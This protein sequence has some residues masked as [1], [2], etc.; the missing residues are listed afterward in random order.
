MVR[1]RLWLSPSQRFFIVVINLIHCLFVIYWSE[2]VIRINERDQG[3][4][5]LAK[6]VCFKTL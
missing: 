2:S 4:K 6:H 5:V 3:S 1:Q